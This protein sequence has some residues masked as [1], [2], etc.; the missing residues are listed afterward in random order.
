L[1]KLGSWQKISITANIATIL[2]SIPTSPT[3]WNL[4]AADEAVLKKNL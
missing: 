2:G 3:Q 1:E 4:R